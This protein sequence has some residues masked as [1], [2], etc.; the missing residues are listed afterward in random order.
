MYGNTVANIG[1]Q[2]GKLK[3]LF[4][5]FL[6]QKTFTKKTPARLGLSLLAF[7]FSLRVLV[8]VKQWKYRSA[9]S[10]EIYKHSHC[11]F[12]SI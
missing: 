7:C 4:K 5:K 11:V 12:T 9:R 8:R 3:C 1:R 10:I 2:Q 6:R